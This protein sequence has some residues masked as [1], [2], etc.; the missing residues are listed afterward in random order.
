MPEI[1][2]YLIIVILTLGV[3]LALSLGLVRWIQLRSITPKILS[4][5]SKLPEH[6]PSISVIVAARNEERT[7]RQCVS[8]IL[9]QYHPIQEVLVVDDSSTDRTPS[10]IRTFELS[11]S[12]VKLLLAPPVP[13]DWTGKTWASAYGADHASGEWL[14]FT[15]ADVELAPTALTGA[16][17]FAKHTSADAVSVYPLLLARGFLASLLLPVM[18]GLMRL[19]APIVSVNSATRES[20]YVFGSF[21][22]IKSDVYRQLGGHGSVRN[23]LL[24]DKA[25]GR[26][27]K[28]S[29]YNLKLA[30]GEEV[31]KARFSDENVR[32]GLERV[33]IY[34]SRG[35]FL[36]AFL[37]LLAMSFLLG[38]PYLALMLAGVFE[39][40]HFSPKSSP[41][42]LMSLASILIL[43]LLYGLETDAAGRDGRRV[44]LA[45]LASACFLICLA[46]AVVK[47]VFRRGV[48]WKGRIYRP[49]SAFVSGAQ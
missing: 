20:A 25:L 31:A 6:N 48:V 1:G 22:L 21:L 37:F 41:V 26:L 47:L 44:I 24:E 16:V 46:S 29:G 3:T 11:N 38:Y 9:A 35:S 30:R 13:H 12:R 7:I 23:Q 28:R 15:D 17:E 18:N 40:S 42:F 34:N 32:H 14:L 33:V 43:L 27:I 2:S 10:V 19:F 45:P 49:V 5:S 8:S 36:Q 39:I 4:A